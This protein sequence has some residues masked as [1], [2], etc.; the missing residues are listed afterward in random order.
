MKM[1]ADLDDAGRE[2][3]MR[4][5]ALAA[6]PLTF[7]S[8]G[9]GLVLS[10]AILHERGGDVGR[11]DPHAF[12]SVG[13]VLLI[14]VFLGVMDGCRTAGTFRR[15]GGWLALGLALASVALF[16]LARLDARVE[17]TAESAGVA[18][19]VFAPALL[20]LGSRLLR[21]NLRAARSEAPSA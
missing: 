2:R 21:R 11:A 14:A 10:H 20:F 12:A 5:T 7:L 16:G 6:G 17:S 13:F 15:I 4:R 9:T 1:P 19:L 18:A 8:A 3:W